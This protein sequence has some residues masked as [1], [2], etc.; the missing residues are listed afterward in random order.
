M[1]F[2][3]GDEVFLTA[4][5]EDS[6]EV[7]FVKRGAS[8]IVQSKLSASEKA[9]FDEAKDKALEPF[10]KSEAFG[11]IATRDVD[12]SKTVP[13]IYVLKWK[14]KGQQREANAR[15]CLQGFQHEGTT[16][17]KAVNVESPTLSKLGRNL[18]FYVTD[19]SYMLPVLGP[20]FRVRFWL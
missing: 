4:T 17:G 11:A 1:L 13:M 15:V 6:E 14:I 7:Y 9:A 3:D 10:L 8:V 5:N 20:G 12:P 16:S 2:A 18:V 19:K